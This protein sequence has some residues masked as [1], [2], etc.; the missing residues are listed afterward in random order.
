[1]TG[2]EALLECSAT[3]FTA[4]Q[5][6]YFTRQMR[7]GQNFL[8]NYVSWKNLNFDLLITFDN[9]EQRI[10]DFSKYIIEGTVYNQLRN[11][12][13]FN[14]CYIDSDNSICWDKDS[15][16][17]SNVTWSNK[18]DIGADICYLESIKQ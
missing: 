2:Q 5:L 9:D 11:K 7:S 13:I 16:I 8:Q 15:T 12:E 10:L 1:I 4:Y 17:D 18:I 3:S 6:F 14:N